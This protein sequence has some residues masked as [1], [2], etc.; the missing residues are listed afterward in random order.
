MVRSITKAFASGA[1]ISTPLLTQRPEVAKRFAAAWDK[2]IMA[3]ATDPTTRDYLTSELS[4]PADLAKVMP[5]QAFTMVK[6]LTPED[7][8][9]IQSFVDIGVTQGVVRE[10]IDVTTFLKPL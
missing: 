8:K 9:D 7:V 4:T 1:G 6:N 2:A 3:I 10:K 5:L